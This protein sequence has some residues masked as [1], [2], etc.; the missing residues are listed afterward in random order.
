MK[1]FS[2]LA[3]AVALWAGVAT[4]QAA[5][6]TPGAPAA[7]T[8]SALAEKLVG[9][10]ADI[11]QGE[12]VQIDGSVADLQLLEDLAVAVRK[13]GAFPMI[14]IESG[15]LWRRMVDEVPERF[16]SQLR[17]FDLNLAGFVSAVIAV[18]IPDSEKALAGVS[19]S[20][21]ALVYKADAAVY[22]RWLDRNVRVVDLGNGLY[23][24]AGRAA[25]FGMSEA[26]LRKIYEDGL[27]VDYSQ[28]QAT[29]ATMK[30]ILSAG[31]RVHLTAPGGTDLTLDIA[32]QSTGTSDGII[33]P[34]KRK[35]GGAA[36]QTWLP[37][38]EVYF[39]TVPDSAEGKV[40]FDHFYFEFKDCRNVAFTVKAGK[41][42][43]ITAETGLE[44]LREVYAAAA[45]GKE[46]LTAIDLGINPN[47][48]LAPGSRL[49]ASMPAGMVS[50]NFG[51]DDW[52]GG[53][54]SNGFGLGGPV[55]YGT[56]TL[57]GKTLIENGELKVK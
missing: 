24:S 46:R 33:T 20:R 40:V 41:I 44:R 56:L 29:A 18:D 38:G 1:S 25:L 14:T 17:Q 57:D 51:D 37:A 11:Q 2:S 4:V 49:R 8:N 10:V 13:R 47:I 45:P 21:L 35:A 42:T 15:T 36:C 7:A 32:G 23:P 52:A 43:G 28:L 6:G 55:A 53:D 39:R 16:D 31:K 3:A 48:R 5:G 9:Q 34:E 12:L 22:K 27:N 19:A 30:S 26:E 50:V 54:L